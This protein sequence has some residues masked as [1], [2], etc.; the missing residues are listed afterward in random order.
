M[1]PVGR[2]RTSR[3]RCPASPAARAARR[4]ACG[5]PTRSDSRRRRGQQASAA[6]A[7]Y[8]RR[9]VRPGSCTDSAGGSPARVSVGAPGSRHQPG[10]EIDRA[11][12]CVESLEAGGSEGAGRNRVN[13]VEASS[14]C[15]PKGVR[16]SRAGHVAAKATHSAPGP[17]WA[18]GLPG[19]EATARVEGWVR[20]RRDPHRQPALGKDRAH[21]AGAEIARSRKGVRGARSTVEARDNRVEGR[22]PALVASALGISARAWP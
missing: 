11:E 8:N 1:E 21:K 9:V 12:R 3:R 22:G 20:N 4:G 5:S 7:G 19:V 16:E 2:R 15:Q 18:L 10:R 17:K 14:D 6:A 13:A